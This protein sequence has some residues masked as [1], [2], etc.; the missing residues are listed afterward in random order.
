MHLAKRTMMSTQLQ[1]EWAGFRLLRVETVRCK[2]QSGMQAT[3]Q[4]TSN[5][6]T[7]I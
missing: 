3:V 1:R 4:S 2:N 6:F 5:C 7:N